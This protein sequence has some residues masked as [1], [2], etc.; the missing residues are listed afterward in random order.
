V[1]IIQNHTDTRRFQVSPELAEKGY[2]RGMGPWNCTAAC[3]GGGVY[4]DVTERDRI[5]AHRHII[6]KYMDESQTPDDSRWFEAHEFAD[7]D[8]PSRRCVGTTIINDKCAFLNRR[9]QCVLQVAATSE[10]MHKWALKPLFCV[11][12]P[13]EI[14]NGVISF[15]GMQQSDHPCCCISDDFAIPLYEAC[16]EELEYLIGEEGYRLIEESDHQRRGLQ[17]T[18]TTRQ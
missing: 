14:S 16:K 7:A 15:D 10:G 6:R 12:F 17:A 11:L 9:G 5:L 1:N 13:L 18:A 4:A 8:F 2:G 3:C